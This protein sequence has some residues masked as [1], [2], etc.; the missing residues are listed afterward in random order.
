MIHA[1]GQNIEL[2]PGFSGSDDITPTEVADLIVSHL[3]PL[4]W[5]DHIQEHG[6]LDPFEQ[7]LIAI[8]YWVAIELRENGVQCIY[9]KPNNSYYTTELPI[10]SIMDLALRELRTGPHNQTDRP[11]IYDWCRQRNM[12][13][14]EACS[15]T[16]CDCFNLTRSMLREV[17]MGNVESIE[18]LKVV[19]DNL[20]TSEL[21][22]AA[23]LAFAEAVIRRREKAS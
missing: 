16:P 7:Q 11:D 2:M 1:H 3:D 4:L 17:F 9:A 12:L 8:D 6:T 19:A 20:E 13:D 10:E 18:E 21:V 22:R 15:Q 5:Q 14:C 23:E